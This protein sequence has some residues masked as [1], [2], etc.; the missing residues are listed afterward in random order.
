MLCRMMALL[1][2][3][4][5]VVPGAHAQAASTSSGQ[6]FRSKQMRLVLPFPAGGPTDLLGRAVA[7]KK[8]EQLGQTMVADNRPGAGGNLGIEI[9]AKAPADGHTAVLVSSV[10]SIAPSL[11][12]K[13]K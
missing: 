8:G 11:Y 1:F 7:Q 10:I 9:A 5:V 3:A 13:L 4:L 6:A 2:L 12:S